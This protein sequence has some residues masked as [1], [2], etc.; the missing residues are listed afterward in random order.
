MENKEEREPTTEEL[1]KNQAYCFAL[2]ANMLDCGAETMSVSIR[3][4]AF[5]GEVLGDFTVSIRKD[6]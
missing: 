1:K 6:K 5:K 2:I 3:E 4:F